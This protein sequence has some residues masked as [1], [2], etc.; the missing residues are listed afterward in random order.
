MEEE[1]SDKLVL[2]QLKLSTAAIEKM[3]TVVDTLNSTM[4]NYAKSIDKMIGVQTDVLKDSRRKTDALD[5]Q[6]KNAAGNK[7]TGNAAGLVDSITA[8]SP[9]LGG[10]GVGLG[11]LGL[12]IGGFFM[13]LAGAEAVMSQFG[14]GENLKKLIIN[15]GDAIESLDVQSMTA[16]GALLTGSALFAVNTGFG[17]QV[18]AATGMT[19]IGA[20]IGGFFA[21]LAAADS[22]MS[23]MNVDGSALKSML[24]NLGD[25]LAAFSSRDLSAL[26]ALL[27]GSALFAANTSFG[28]QFKIATGMTAIGAGIGGFFAGLT[29]VTDLA[30]FLGADG[31]GIKNMMVNIADGLAAFSSRDLGAIGAMLGVGGLFGAVPGGLAVAGSAALGMTAI[32][33]GI[34]GFFTGIS[35]VGDIA[36]Y[37]GAD[38]SGI[39]TMMTNIAEG[40]SAFSGV[41]ASKVLGATGAMAALSPA[42]IAFFGAQGISS[43][44]DSITRFVTWVTG[45]DDP[46]TTVVEQLKKFEA[47]DFNKLA[48]SDGTNIGTMLSNIATGLSAFSSASFDSAVLSTLTNVVNWFSGNEDPFSAIAQVGEKAD[49]INAAANAIERIAIAMTKFA[50]IPSALEFDFSTMAKQLVSI[51]PLLDAVLHG[52]EIPVDWGFDTTIERGLLDE[53]FNLDAGI[54]AI[55]KVKQALT[56]MYGVNTSVGLSTDV[57]DPNAITTRATSAVETA[58]TERAQTESS[59]MLV[60][61]SPT[62]VNGGSTSNVTNSTTIIHAAPHTSLNAFMPI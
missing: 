30:S 19:M 52:G 56:A 8:A 24:T 21:G 12:G 53:G 50:E 38:G 15:F 48:S 57:Q 28:S 41:D 31:S 20:G 47:I 11:S 32:G 26:G 46:I 51:V 34:G 36:S 2:E 40:L 29:S 7:S 5:V 1:K 44:M 42:L 33:L 58:A 59:A 35:A 39:K 6:A 17:S 54:D 45:G 22:T 18:K 55:N 27:T 25:G 16:I 13:G 23:W 49:Q 43:V 4:V 10:L 37:F 9:T 14:T 62:V 3:S 61:N 60:N